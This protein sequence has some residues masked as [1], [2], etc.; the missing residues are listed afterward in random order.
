[1]QL[2][3][4]KG[5]ILLPRIRLADTFLT[6]A[7]GLL[8]SPAIG[9]EAGLWIKP[10][11][12]VHSFFMTYPIDVVFLD[13]ELNIVFILK[14]MQPWRT[15]PICRTAGSVLEIRAGAADRLGLQVGDRL[16]FTE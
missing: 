13:K 1:M 5:N 2:K 4:S 6:R 14:N 11:R 15:S 10:C 16:E 12:S 9:E 7:R 3:D 8:F